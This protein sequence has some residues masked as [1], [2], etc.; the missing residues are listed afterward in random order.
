MPYREA[1]GD[2][3]PIFFPYPGCRPPR[4]SGSIAGG[5]GKAT[6][7]WQGNAEFKTLFWGPAIT[8]GG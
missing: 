7:S 2:D 4:K 6:A 8:N 3:N 1:T 5:A